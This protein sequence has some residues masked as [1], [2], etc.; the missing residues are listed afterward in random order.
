MDFFFGGDKDASTD[1]SSDR[2]FVRGH[3]RG[4]GSSKNQVDVY[5]GKA[6]HVVR[7]TA[8]SESVP[9]ANT[10]QTTVVTATFVTREEANAKPA[11]CCIRDTCFLIHFLRNHSCKTL[12]TLKF[13]ILRST[14]KYCVSLQRHSRTYTKNCKILV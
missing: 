12:P 11:R 13:Y 3:A 10:S 7:I 6:P 4:E 8:M 2:S 9:V 14:L 5:M 1:G